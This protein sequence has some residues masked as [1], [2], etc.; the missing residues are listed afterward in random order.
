QRVDKGAIGPGASTAA[1]AVAAIAAA[2]AA[3]AAT[4]AASGGKRPAPPVRP[5]LSINVPAQGAGREMSGGA[6]SASRKGKGQKPSGA[7]GGGADEGGQKR[8][9]VAKG[10][11]GHKE[12]TGRSL[13]AVMNH[14]STKANTGHLN[15][16]FGTGGGGGGVTPPA[17]GFRVGNAKVAGSH[18]RAATPTHSGGK[19]GGSGGG[20]GASAGGATGGTP[21]SG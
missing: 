14:G 1:K 17:G 18:P 3:A 16:G 15:N 13:T 2:A 21:N 7:R 10:S 5:Q 20:V 4:A 12:A 9:K 6:S 11:E 8:A 19:K